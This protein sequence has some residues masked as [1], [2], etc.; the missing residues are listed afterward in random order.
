VSDTDRRDIQACLDGDDEAYA[1]LVRRYE[2]Q[3]ARQMHRFDRD[4]AVREELVQD[5]FVEVYYSLEGFRGDAPFL[6]WMRRIATRVGYRHWKRQSRRTR[7]VP[8]EEWDGVAETDESV[9]PAKAGA[10]LHALFA[11]LPPKERL[12]MT[13]LYFEECSTAE[14]AERMGW[15]RPMVKMRAYRARNKLKEVAEREHLLEKLGWIS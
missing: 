8:L 1:R 9:D 14:I 7:Q 6:H 2:P 12:V 3:V 11:R 15:T 13:L 10:M 4:P 5:V